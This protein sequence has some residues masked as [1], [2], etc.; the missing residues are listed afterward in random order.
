MS[1]PFELLQVER[2]V[3]A[4]E[5]ANAVARAVR[6]G[7]PMIAARQAMDELRDPVRRE[8]AALLAPSQSPARRMLPPPSPDQD[9][10]QFALELLD[11]LTDEVESRLDEPD[12]MPR[13]T[14]ERDV[15][16]YAPAE[17]EDPRP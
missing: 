16:A 17:R 12:V 13:M 1:D 2:D 7:V 10:E 4:S 6:R 15:R 9:A 14:I 3:P 5:L 8:A 11:L